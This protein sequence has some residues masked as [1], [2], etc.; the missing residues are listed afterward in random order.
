M[1]GWV[2]G[3]ICEGII[4]YEDSTERRNL[5]IKMVKFV[6][7]IILISHEGFYPFQGQTLTSEFNLICSLQNVIIIVVESRISPSGQK[8]L[9]CLLKMETVIISINK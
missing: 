3:W 5:K 4:H 2:D 6:F 9:L 7:T 1:C 8:L